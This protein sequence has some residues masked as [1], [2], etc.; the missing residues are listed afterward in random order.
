MEIH[1]TVAHKVIQKPEKVV[2]VLT[3]NDFYKKLLTLY[4]MN[5]NCLR[6]LFLFFNSC[7]GKDSYLIKYFL[8]CR[9]KTQEK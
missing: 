5:N 3:G 1:H 9:K 6:T 4:G 7:V 8:Q 2:V